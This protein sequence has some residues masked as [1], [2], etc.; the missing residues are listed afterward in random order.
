[1]KRLRVCWIVEFV[2]PFVNLRKKLPLVEKRTAAEIKS[3]QQRDSAIE[4]AVWSWRGKAKDGHALL[5]TPNNMTLTAEEFDLAGLIH[6]YATIEKIPFT[7]AMERMFD[8][9]KQHPK[10]LERYTNG[11]VNFAEQEVKCIGFSIPKD[12][13]VDPRT[14]EIIRRA[15]V[16]QAGHP[17]CGFVHAV[18]AVA[19]AVSR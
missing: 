17:D 9:I 13:S 6:E 5:K 2:E 15:R 3:N 4:G 16:Y 11:D 7:T 8:Y 18:S 12:N 1:M 14:M 19:A 10:M